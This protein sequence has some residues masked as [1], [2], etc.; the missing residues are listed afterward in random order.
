MTDSQI[1]PGKGRPTPSRKEREAANRKPIVVADR[2]LARK[3]SKEKMRDERARVNAGYAAGEEKYL[4]ARDR[5]PQK[6]WVRDWIDARFSVGELVIPGMFLAILVMYLPFPGIEG[7]ITYGLI[8]FFVI[9]IG[10]SAI[11]AQ[12]CQRR[13]DARYGTRAERVR[14]YAAMRALQLRPMRMPKP[15]VKRFRFPD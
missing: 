10:D 12:I 7:Y 6:R 2:S 13:I 4:P 8:A 9:V 15:Q 14:W 11:A 1:D 5:G 3:Q